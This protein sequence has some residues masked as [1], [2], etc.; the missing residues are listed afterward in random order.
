MAQKMETKIQPWGNSMAVRLP[1]SVVND[2]K[3]K[4]GDAL[5][6][7]VQ[8]GAIVLRPVKKAGHPTLAEMVGQSHVDAYE[9]SE[10]VNWRGEQ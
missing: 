2:M 1:S 10:I 7:D 9:A 3:L 4:Q 8:D 5:Q 6:I